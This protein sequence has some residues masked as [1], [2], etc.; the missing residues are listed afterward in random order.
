[1]IEFFLYSDLFHFMGMDS[2]LATTNTPATAPVSFGLAATASFFPEVVVDAANVIAG[3]VALFTF[4]AI[5]WQLLQIKKQSESEKKTNQAGMMLDLADRWSDVL[6]H[7]YEV[8]RML[9]NPAAHNVDIE[10]DFHNDYRRLM[11]SDFW[12]KDLRPV[13]NFYEFLGLM[14]HQGNISAKEAFVLVSVDHYDWDQLA[15]DGRD[16]LETS[17]RDGDFFKKVEDYLKLLRTY[18]RDIYVFYDYFLAELYHLNRLEPFLPRSAVSSALK[19]DYDRQQKRYR[20]I[21]H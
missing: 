11:A 17:F 2:L 14:I 16:P 9:E 10:A 7:R 5:F 1:M 18:R 13:F 20:W 3:A 19:L 12:R 4:P 21:N 8:M 6:S 15:E